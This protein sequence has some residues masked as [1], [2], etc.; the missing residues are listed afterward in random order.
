M[1]VWGGG[2]FN[3]ALEDVERLIML[4]LFGKEN[5]I[6]IVLEEDDL[7]KLKH[8]TVTMDTSKTSSKSTYV[9]RF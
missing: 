3:P 7:V 5:A 9:T 4:S 2:V 1:A 8:L 6:K